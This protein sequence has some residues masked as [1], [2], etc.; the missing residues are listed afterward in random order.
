MKYGMFI[1][2]NTCA[3]CGACVMACKIQNGTPMGMYWAK[4]IAHE[5]G[6]YPNVKKI[7]LPL[8]C[9]HCSNAP[10][11]HVCPT[12]ATYYAEDGTVQI[13]TKKCIG[14]RMCMGAC[15]Y[16]ARSFNWADPAE[17]PYFEGQELT[18][19]EKAHAGEHHIGVAEKCILCRD[20]IAEGLEPACVQTCITKCRV[21]GDIEDPDSEVSKMIRATDARCLLADYGTKPSMY[22]AGLN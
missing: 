12:G 14:C 8:G 9:Q 5:E 16:G 15:P 19:F 18:P 6:T 2:L 13:N 4:V 1:D 20:R 3:G 10:C 22:Y 7:V 17:T 11:E 21:F